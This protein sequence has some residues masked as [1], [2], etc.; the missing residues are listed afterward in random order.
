MKFDRILLL[1]L[2]VTFL[3]GFSGQDLT[4]QVSVQIR[5]SE[6]RVAKSTVQ[7]GD[8]ATLSVS[9]PEV[10]K[11]LQNIDVDSFNGNANEI[12]ITKE[13]IRIRLLLAGFDV[14][15]SDISGPEE[16]KV[17]RI[18]QDDTRQIIQ[19]LLNQQLSSQ[20]AIP[21]SAIQV[22]IDSNFKIAND[23]HMDFRTLKLEP[24][25]RPDI[26]LGKSTLPTMIRDSQNKFQPMNVPVTVAI[27]RELAV[28]KMDI[29]RG[30]VLTRENLDSVRRPVSTNST[31]FLTMAHALGKESNAD[32]ATYE[33][34][35]PN[36][37]KSVVVKQ[38]A[39]IK[40]N[41]IVSAVLRSGHL[42]VTLKKIKALE[43]ANLGDTIQVI[44]MNNN[45]RL[46][47]KVIDTYT[48]ELR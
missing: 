38:D 10:A 22:T 15:A 27:Y 32:I 39:L 29:A 25:G 6:L 34:I 30:T 16:F 28:A 14:A 8:I 11:T 47:A 33:L 13:Q 23:S 18:D 21:E 1:A 46:F 17:S 31:G 19:T 43:D 40:K 20:F 9:S 41:S 48:V 24:L 7:L 2:A 3:G 26:P 35:K 45:E 44:N 37:I 42:T 5:N 12:W 36:A 4:A